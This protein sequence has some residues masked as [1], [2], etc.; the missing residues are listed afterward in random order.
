MVS[1]KIVTSEVSN[2]NE[3]D[4]GRIFLICHQCL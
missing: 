2:E 4:N 1:I 3:N